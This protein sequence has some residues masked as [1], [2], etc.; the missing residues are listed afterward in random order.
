MIYGFQPFGYEG[1]LVNIEVDLRRGIP[2]VDIV[3]VADGAVK[4]LRERTIAAIRNSGFE[5][6]SERVLISLSPADLKKEGAQFDL[7]IALAIISAQN[8]DKSYPDVLVMGELL[9]SGEVK[10]TK[11]TYSALSNAVTE[12]IRYAIIPSGSE[13]AIP[14]GIKIATVSNLKD[15]VKV[16]F[17]NGSEDYFHDYTRPVDTS[18]NVEFEYVEPDES[19]DTIKDNDYLHNINGMKYAVAV[20]VAGHHNIITVGSPGSGKTLV[21]QRMPQLMPKLLETEQNQVTRIW[22]LAGL[23][24]P[25]EGYITRRPF[26]MPHQTASIEGICG[27]GLSCRPGEI[28]LAH[29]GVLFLDEAAEF[30]SSV[31]QMLRVPIE[32]G[33]ITLCRAG[34]C[35][36]FPA[37]FQLAM[38]VNPCPCGNLGS[39]NK[40]CLCSA[41]SVDQ[42]WK[43][44]SAPLL[45]R[46]AIRYNVNSDKFENCISWIND[47]SLENLR[48]MIKTAWETQ[49]ARQGKLNQ[50]LAPNEEVEHIKLDTAVDKYLTNYAMKYDLS[51]RAIVN[52]KKVARTVADMDSSEKILKKHL[53]IACNLH[54][55]L[56]EF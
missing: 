5:F 38:A 51:P 7:A 37:H 53:V 1:S 10:P 44:F 32:S 55:A 29:N 19:L 15:A 9:L 52:I 11:A 41:K 46:V 54:P 24:R 36:V 30:R 26:R 22:S 18:V 43:K 56:P 2:S 39:S 28:S 45:D 27:G 31:L 6:P 16:L 40:I 34:R 50:D 35:T 3:G 13:M 48:N 49:Y 25:N 20:A 4:E 14:N 47:F 33:Q 17:S 21:L 12:Q 42:Y 23:T 8:E